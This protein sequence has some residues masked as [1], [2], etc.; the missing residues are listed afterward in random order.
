MTQNVTL[1]D[2][3]AG[4]A[5]EPLTFAHFP[6][7]LACFLFRNHGFVPP[8]KL[9]KLLGTTVEK[10]TDTCSQMGLP[11]FPHVDTG[12]FRERGYISLLRQNWHLLPYSQL[13]ELLDI[14]AAE[15]KFRLKEDDFLFGKLGGLK[16]DAKELRWHD[17]S[18]AETARLKEIGATVRSHFNA[19]EID[20]FRP[21]L[22]ERRTALKPPESCGGL[23]LSYPY[24]AGCGDPLSDD[25]L[26]NFSEKMLTEYA[27]SGIN[28]LW[29]QALLYK[30]VPWDRAP[31]M[32]QGWERRMRN[33]KHISDRA[34]KFGIGIYLYFNE[35]RTISAEYAASFRDLKGLDF[36]NGDISLCTSLPGVRAYL[37]DALK[38]LFTECPAL[39]GILSITRSENPTNCASQ[40]RKGECPRCAVRPSEEIIA[41]VLNAFSEG[42]AAANPKARLLAHSWAW[43]ETWLENIISRLKGNTT[44]LAVSEWGIQTDCEGIKSEVI[45]Y[46]ISHPGPGLYAKKVWEAGT[47]ANL[48]NAAKIQVNNS[49][50]LSAIPY[51]PVFDL[52]EK[53]IDDLRKVGVADFMLCWTHGGGPSPLLALLFKSKE[54]VLSALYGEKAMPLLS[55]AT[56]EFSRAFA[57]F[58]FDYVSAIYF[59]PMNYGPMNL[60]FQAPTHYAATMVGFPY[61]DLAKWRGKYPEELFSRTFA[62][63]AGGWENG[64]KMLDQAEPLIQDEFR[65][66][67]KELK[68]YSIAAYCHLKSTWNQIEFIRLR[69][70]P[71]A[72]PDSLRSILQDEIEL[73]KATAKLQCEDACVGFE[74]SNHYFYTPALLMEKVINCEALLSELEEKDERHV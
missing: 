74:A 72:D 58:P 45:D 56:A 5:P 28:A 21:F 69:G 65:R 62:R 19:S 26:E 50:E 38:R 36:K 25:S 14:S 33:L 7:R 15:L 1:Q 54:E 42:M 70:N 29:F 60:L 71:S 2:L 30:L 20:M 9:A 3:P 4:S 24:S 53:H 16:P 47:R 8:E 46:S 31:E 44:V 39:A 32:S 73:A 52:I 49:W 51:I 10:I 6:N 37:K 11:P 67:F 43:D 41:E 48:R 22:F 18:P 59:A 17:F 55:E 23:R 68:R 64:L 63:I 13:L 61:D 66:N 27:D 12:I 40:A 35:P 57:A 34:A